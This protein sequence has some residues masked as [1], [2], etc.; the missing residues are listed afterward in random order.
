MNGGLDKVS[1]IIERQGLG[2]VIIIVHFKSADQYEKFV[3]N[4]HKYITYD[5]ITI[6]ACNYLHFCGQP[7]SQRLCNI[8]FWCCTG[9]F[10]QTCV[11]AV[12]V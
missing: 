2:L 9:L 12:N 4:Q 10:N 3:V 8:I 5:T 11:D 7:R 1:C 6:H